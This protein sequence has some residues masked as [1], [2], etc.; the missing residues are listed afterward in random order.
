MGQQTLP[1][2]NTKDVILSLVQSSWAKIIQ[3]VLDNPLNDGIAIKG[4]KLASGNNVVNHKLQRKMQGYLVTAMYD[5]YAQLYTTTS[6]QPT[7]NFNLNA[8]APTTV[9]LW[10]F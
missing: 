10:V 7:L 6:Q 8:S 4:I 5:S 9:D 3:P 2:F 1:S